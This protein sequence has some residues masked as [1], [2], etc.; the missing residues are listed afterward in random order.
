VKSAPKP[1]HFRI[2]EWLRPDRRRQ[3]LV[4]ILDLD[5]RLGH[6]CFGRQP[7]IGDRFPNPIPERSARDVAGGAAVDEIGRNVITAKDRVPREER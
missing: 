6:G 1:R 4:K 5:R 3:P 7:G 2:E